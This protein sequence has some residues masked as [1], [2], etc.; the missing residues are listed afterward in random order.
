MEIHHFTDRSCYSALNIDLHAFSGLT[1]HCG[2]CMVTKEVHNCKHISQRHIFF[3]E[4]IASWT[5]IPA[6]IRQTVIVSIFLFCLQSQK[7]RQR[8]WTDNFLHQSQPLRPDECMF[9]STPL[10]TPQQ[11]NIFYL[12]VFQIIAVDKHTCVSLFEESSIVFA[13]MELNK[14]Q[15]T[16]K[17]QVCIT[18]SAQSQ[19][20]HCRINVTPWVV[21]SKSYLLL[22]CS[23]DFDRRP[24]GGVWKW[25]G[26]SVRVVRW[27]PTA[28]PYL[29]QSFSPG[30]R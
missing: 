23:N 19:P 21:I 6:K 7:V 3:P 22:R 17:K 13:Y 5:L 29:P 2:Q 12:L 15:L 16:D 20:T 26:K 9:E 28:A 14:D 18:E 1:G 30:N 8:N 10:T 11:L 27:K 25:R 24:L 4:K